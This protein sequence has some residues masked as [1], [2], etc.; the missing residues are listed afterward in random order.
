MIIGAISKTR[1][2]GANGVSQFVFI[3]PVV[4]IIPGLINQYHISPSYR[5]NFRHITPA[6]ITEVIEEV[7]VYRGRKTDLRRQIEREDEEMLAII[8]AFM[9]MID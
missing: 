5:L 7:G 3:K 8:M 9:R 4:V 2:Y 6:D 1:Y